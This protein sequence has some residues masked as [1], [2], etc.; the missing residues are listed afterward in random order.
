[1]TTIISIAKTTQDTEKSIIEGLNFIITHLKEPIWPKTISTKTTEGRQ[2]L[3]SSK[4]EAIARYKAANFL[5]C[6]ISAYPYCRCDYNVSAMVGCQTI[7][8]IMIDLDLSTFNSVQALDRALNRTFKSIRE[9]F[10]SDFKPSVL[11]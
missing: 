2:V 9:A 1:M 3:V 4:Q 5:D 6:R 11:W 10:G 7:Y 8:L